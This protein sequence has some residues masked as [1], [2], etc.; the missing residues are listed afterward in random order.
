M[1]PVDAQLPVIAGVQYIDLSDFGEL[2]TIN[3][4]TQLKLLGVAFISPPLEPPSIAAIKPAIPVLH[5][6]VPASASY[7]QG[8]T[9]YARG[10]NFVNGAVINFNGSSRTTVFLSPTN[11][12]TNLAK[13]DISPEGNYPVYVINPTGLTSITLNFTSLKPH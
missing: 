6:L 12:G 2:E 3:A 5:S 1:Q 8:L 4:L 10:A 9:L 13:T 11:L 7:N